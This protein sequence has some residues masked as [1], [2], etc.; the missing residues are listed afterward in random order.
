MEQ[1]HINE[2]GFPETAQIKTRLTMKNCVTGTNLTPVLLGFC[3]GCKEFSVLGRGGTDVNILFSLTTEIPNLFLFLKY[4]DCA[5]AWPCCLESSY[6]SWFGSPSLTTGCNSQVPPGSPL[7]VYLPTLKQIPAGSRLSWSLGWAQ[8]P[9]RKVINS[10]EV[11][12]ALKCLNGGE[13]IS[14]SWKS[15][16]LF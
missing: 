15:K 3:L 4:P 11:K 6:V 2:R 8:I 5:H 12:H 1:S 16:L 14:I 9:P 13:E 10:L 7:F